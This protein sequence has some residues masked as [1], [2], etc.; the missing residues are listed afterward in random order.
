MDIFVSQAQGRVPVTVMHLAGRINLGNASEIEQKAREIYQ[1]GSRYLVIDL[2]QVESLTS[3][4][5]RVLHIIYKLYRD[6]T[7]AEMG[8]GAL[9]ASDASSIK[10]PYIK[11]AGPSTDIRRVLKIAGFELFLEIYDTVDEA[12]ASF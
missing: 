2:S 3:A 1:E 6:A 12:V 8:E 7:P 11:L 9:D 4:G 10:S 5:L